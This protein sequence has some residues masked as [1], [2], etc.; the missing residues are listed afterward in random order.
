MSGDRGVEHDADDGAEFA[1]AAP[2]EPHPSTC[3]FEPLAHRAYGDSDDYA[4]LSDHN[5]DARI[6][7]ELVSSVPDNSD[8]SSDDS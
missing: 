8:S 3:L 7:H 1:L 4:S 5:N 6:V 2:D